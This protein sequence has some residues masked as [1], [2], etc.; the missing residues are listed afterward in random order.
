MAAPKKKKSGV[1]TEKLEL[2][3]QLIAAY[4]EIERKGANNAY[5]AVN[6]NMFLLMQ[7]SGILA[8]RLPDASR[9]EFV[10]KYKT[11]LYEAYGVIMNEYVTV[12]DGLLA[13]TKELQKYLGQ[14]YAYAKTLKAKP[15]RKKS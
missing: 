13:R 11:K 12:P 7:P 1:P 6:G 14:S 10:K 15:S 2:F 8:M 9:E 3:D 5:A 4:P